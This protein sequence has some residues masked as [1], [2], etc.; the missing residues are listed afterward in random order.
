[1]DQQAESKEMDFR[2]ALFSSY[3]NIAIMEM[4][5]YNSNTDHLRPTHK[6]ILYLYCIWS[7]NGCT[8]TDL[9][10]LFNSSKALVSQTI[11]GMEEK[12][13]IIREKDPED[14]RRQIIRISPERVADSA[15]EISIIER[16]IRQ[17][18]NEY[19]DEDISRAAKIM[20]DLTQNMVDLSIRDTKKQ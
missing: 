11:I 8:A 4:K 5:L 10:E 7:K 6:E 1:M 2:Q 16:S 18:A 3:A 15:T 13:Y 12:G 17:L 19:S 9:V 20:L 14:N